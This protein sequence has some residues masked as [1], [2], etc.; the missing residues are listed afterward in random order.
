V[1]S[2][3]NK[4]DKTIRIEGYAVQLFET[5]NFDS[6]QEETIEIYPYSTYSINKETGE[7][8]SERGIFA[9][10][11]IDSVNIYFNNERV[12]QFA[13][14]RNSEMP[15][16]REKKNLLNMEFFSQAT[17]GKKKPQFI[18]TYTITNKDY[19]NAEVINKTI[20]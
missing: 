20:Q 3:E 11:Y 17:T 13:C 16:C 14:F 2:V 12:D 4:T 9:I 5:G 15:L 6:M 1:Y 18:Y 8:D 19:E 10:S 7:C